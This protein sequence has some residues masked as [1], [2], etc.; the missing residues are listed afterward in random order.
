MSNI[1]DQMEEIKALISSDSKT[2]RSFGYSTLLHFQEQSSDSPPSI[3]A[4]IQSSRG[5]INLIVSDIH[6]EDEEVASQALKCLGFMIYH[7]SL[8]ATIP[9]EDGRLVLESL[10]KLITVT[11]MKSVCNLGV[12]CI[13]M[14]QFDTPL[15]AACFDTLLPAVVHALDNPSGSLSTT[16]EAL[17]AVA[18]LTAQ[19]SEVMRESSHLWAPPIYRR[20]LSIDKRER[21]MS[22]RCLLKIRST[23]LPAPTSLSKAI[24]ED[25]RKNRLT[26]MKGCLDKGMKVQAV[27]AW[28]WFISFLGSGALKN[29]HLVN[30]MLKVLEQTFSDH[31][32]QVQIAS[33]VAWQGLIDALVHPQILSCKKNASSQLQTSSGKNSE[34][35]LNG[36]SKSLKLAMTPLIGIISSKCDVSVLSSCL[37]TWCYL[38]H[39]LD[40]SIN[41]PSVIKLALDPMF[42]AIFKMGPDSKSIQL[43]N[44]CLDL[45]EDCISAKCS[46]LISDPKDQVNLCLSARTILPSSG[47][48]SWK[49]YPIKWLP[50]DLSQLDFYLK[51]IAIII[52]HVAPTVSPES[53]K[54]AC[55]AAVRI[56]RSVLKGVQMEFRNPL[57]NY[58][59][60]MFCLNRIFSFMK[61][62]SEDTSSEG[63]GDLFNTSL[64]LIEAAVD[65]LE[66]SIMESPLY[67]VALDI[68]YVGTLDS[69]KHSKIQHQCSFM[70][71]V[72]PM[73]YLTVLYLSLVVQLTTI[74][75]LEMELILPRLQSFYK[76]VL[77][78]DDPLESFLASVG[79][80]YGHIGFKYMEI[81]MV[82]V[83]CLNGYIDGMKD[84]S[85][86]K[87][88]SD[89]SFYR[90][91][92]HLLSYPF[93]LL[94][95]SEKDLTLLKSGDT[96]KESFVLS[97]ERKLEQV[98]EIWKSLYGSVCVAYFKLFA[99]NTL[100]CDLCA[101]LNSYFDENRSIFEYNSELGLCNKD[102][103]FACI[104]FSGNVL[105]C[106]LEQKLTSDTGESGKECSVCIESSGLINI[107]EFASRVM[108]FFYI[109]M[110]KEP[111]SGVVNSRVFSALTL[112]I[113]RLHSKQ[114]ILSFFEIVSGPLLQW[115]SH[116]DI[117]D[118]N[119]KDK[120]GILWAEILNRLRRSQPLLTF[121]SSFLKLQASLLE[122]TLDHWNTF[123]SD[124]TIIFWNSTF[125]KQVNLEY[126]QNLLHVLHKLSRNG[127]ISLY[128]RSKSF[129]ARCST[130]E[131]ATATKCCKITSTQNRSSKRVELTEE[132]MTAGFN[133]KVSPPLNS[134]RKR[135]EL[136]EHQKEVRRAQQGRAR[137]CNGHGPGVRTYTSL[138]FSQ[139]NEE[140][141]DSQD[142]RDSEAML[143]MWRRVG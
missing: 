86:F 48:Y 142:I 90:A 8:I 44:F 47:K 125:G 6:H 130:L 61:K 65:E 77:S 33:L 131:T 57:N 116:Q 115:L 103:E 11:K 71:M 134:K 49:Q 73:V 4:L 88:D 137:D 54:S 50:W 34:L 140:S 132:G 107:F 124:E 39:K 9:A 27:Q 68:N 143:E 89:S 60:I 110:A 5:L 55:D 105:V 51:M 79:L 25:M 96:L 97:E 84:L 117:K 111:A 24:I 53:K 67:K 21:D 93:I 112:F 32:P 43:W 94:S 36:F 82:M 70:D 28:G 83:T 126:P 102:L 30:D 16:F 108:K 1:S 69:V 119:V 14:Q 40:T 22:E 26:G 18:K 122:K 56:F 15:L 101:M 31:N 35:T 13:S 113:S 128:N 135:V 38:L 81:W 118:E 3:Q 29:R 100:G 139:G 141:Q 10:A 7:P 133:Q 138:D 91:V 63:V 80:L 66:P 20:L 12:W 41:S 78:S 123:I 95:W 121:D 75:I 45:L 87:T 120:L 74:S 72:S 85:L 23:I 59:N 2:D 42:Q 58:D 106:I 19:M 109:N 136:T 129:V 17:Q 114:D 37:N 52:T 104:S 62:V 99:T 127:R 76:S 92:C 46:D 64:Y 98:I